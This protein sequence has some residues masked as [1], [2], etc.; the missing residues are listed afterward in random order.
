MRILL[1]TVVP[2]PPD[3]VWG[4][5]VTAAG[6]DDELRPWLTMRFPRGWQGRTLEDLPVGEPLGRA[7]LLLLGLVPVEYDDLRLDAVVP[8]RSFHERSTMMLMSTWWHD[9]EVLES[10]EGSTEVV[11]TLTFELRRP[12][13]ALAPVAGRVV[14]SLF[15]HRHRRLRRHFSRAR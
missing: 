3:Q 10:A 15:A 6:I 13:R 14:Q 7:W 11:D 4:R 8:G 1:R 5:V 12:V 9:R 2:A